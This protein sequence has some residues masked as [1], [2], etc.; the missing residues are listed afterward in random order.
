LF[1]QETSRCCITSY[2][3]RG[4]PGPVQEP[5]ETEAL[6]TRLHGLAA[7]V[8]PVRGVNPDPEIPGD[9]GQGYEDQAQVRIPRAGVDACL[10]PPP[11]AGFDAEPLAV[12]FADLDRSIRHAPR[13]EQQLLLNLRSPPAR[14]FLQPVHCLA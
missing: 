6:E 14:R 7:A 2:D 13:A 5:F 4:R 3:D 8:C 10:P 11:E 1:R 12:A 9:E